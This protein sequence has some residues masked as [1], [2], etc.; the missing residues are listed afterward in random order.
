M[1]SSNLE[2]ALSKI[3]PHTASS[4]PHQKSPAKVLTALEATFEEQKAEKTPA[5]YFAGLLTLFESTL[6][7]EKE[8]AFKFGDGDRLPAELYLLALICPFVPA[9][10]IRANLN[11]LMALTTPLWSPINAHAPAL[12]SL[13][14]L[15][16]SILRALDRVQ[17][18]KQMVRQSFATVLQFCV[19]PRPKVRKRAADIVRDVLASPPSP[20]LRHPYAER[21]GEWSVNALSEVNTLS[22]GKQKE[23]ANVDDVSSAAIHLISFV[24]PILPYMP[25]VVSVNLLRLIY[26]S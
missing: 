8:T 12:R 17:L 24:R 19:D 2:T 13:L 10:I 26:T 25:S 7:Q 3:R 15:Y 16:N 18:E 23:K 4:L 21:V 6:S 22:S 1:S 11:T 20:L 14:T 5:A 9:P